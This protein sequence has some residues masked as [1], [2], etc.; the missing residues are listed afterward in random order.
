MKKILLLLAVALTTASIAMAQR[1]GKTR[2][3]IGPELG[4][5][6][7]NPL[8]DVSGN[9]GWGLGIGASAEVEHF[10]RENMS[11]TFHAGFV[12]YNG[13]STGSSTKNKAY[14]VIP[15]TIG[16]RAYAGNR[17]HAGAQFGVG[18]NN[19]GG[20]GQTAFAYSPQVGYNFSKNDKPLDITIKYDG[21][22]CHGNFSALGIRLSIIL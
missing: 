4:I 17:L 16:A 8:K 1:N 19:I 14:T 2:F 22:A 20:I 6:A 10:F 18:L 12:G 13:R 11:G 5:A 3:S 15:L 21:Y 7:S 9:K